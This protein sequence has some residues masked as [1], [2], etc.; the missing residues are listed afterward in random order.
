[1]II[2]KFDTKKAYHFIKENLKYKKGRFLFVVP[3]C[4]D[5]EQILPIINLLR[6][7]FATLFFDT[8]IEI[9][10]REK[11]RNWICIFDLPNVDDLFS[12]NEKFLGF[13][14]PRS[15]NVV[16]KNPII[17]AYKLKFFIIIALNNDS[18][19]EIFSKILH[20]CYSLNLDC[21]LVGC[22]LKCAELVNKNNFNPVILFNKNDVQSN[23][24]R[25]SRL[26]ISDVNSLF[27]E[28][29]NKLL[30]IFNLSISTIYNEISMG[31]KRLT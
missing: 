9:P 14:I 28:T 3:S 27:F 7:K 21:I 10:E 1:M 31:I 17:D 12:F 11:Q 8:A 13:P 22:K 19:I 25:D 20:F 23:L 30:N 26:V 6:T 24:V 4:E 5:E 16:F 18:D 2:S 15:A 29:R